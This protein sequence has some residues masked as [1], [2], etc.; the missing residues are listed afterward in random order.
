M[1]VAS[2]C[3]P[4]SPP[5]LDFMLEIFVVTIQKEPK[6][7]IN[8]KTF[9]SYVTEGFIKIYTASR[10][11]L[12]KPLALPPQSKCD[13]LGLVEDPRPG[14]IEVLVIAGCV[15]AMTSGS[16]LEEMGKS[17]PFKYA[18]NLLQV[19]VYIKTPAWEY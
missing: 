14:I 11:L 15:D 19:S 8:D 13:V 9:P 16:V 4:P 12:L 5:G 18:D 6:I 3:N 2:I 10:L 17:C 7:M 1:Y